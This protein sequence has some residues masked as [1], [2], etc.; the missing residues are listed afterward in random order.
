MFRDLINDEPVFVKSPFR[1]PSMH[2]SE[3]T[4]HHFRKMLWFYFIAISRYSVRGFLANDKMR[5]D[6][7]KLPEIQLQ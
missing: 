3:E 7:K 4:D 5:E 2:L 1:S 6:F